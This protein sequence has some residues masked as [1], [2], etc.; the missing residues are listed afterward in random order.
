[1]RRRYKAA[2]EQDVAVSREKFLRGDGIERYRPLGMCDH[3]LGHARYQGELN[4]REYLVRTQMS[5]SQRATAISHTAPR[6]LS[7]DGEF[8]SAVADMI[9]T[10]RSGARMNGP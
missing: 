6:L 5:G 1:M 10:Q 9:G 2:L 7:I 4:Q 3:D 8:P